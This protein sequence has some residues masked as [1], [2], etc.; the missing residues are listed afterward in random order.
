MRRLVKGVVLLGTV[1][2]LASAQDAAPKRKAARFRWTSTAPVVLP[3]SDAEH[4]V[5]AVK[6]PSIVFANGKYHVFMTTAGAKGWGLAYASFRRWEDAPAAPLTY[7]D[8]SPIGPGYRA[9]PQVFFF[10]PQKRW[11]MVFQGGDPLYSTTTNIDDPMSWSAPKPFF[12]A[13][14]DVVKGKDGN[15]T[16]LDFWVICDD[17]RCHL[18]NTG[19]NGRLYRSETALADFPRGFGKTEVVLEDARDR[20]FE[21]SMTYRVAGTPSYVT[22]VEAIGPR[23]RYFRAWTSDRLDGGWKPL[24]DSLADPFAGSAN[25][26]YPGGRWTLDVSHGEMIRAGNDQHLTLDPCRPLRF[27]YQGVDPKSAGMDYL[28]LPYRLGLLTATAPNPLSA[29]CRARPEG[30]GKRR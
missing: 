12:A 16:W 21:A 14:P 23:G 20:L 22:M 10:A 18:F 29:M 1:A 4:P 28:M 8:R 3:R 6:D 15:A 26:A 19:D 5:V 9:A 25:V 27:L 13:V 30:G 7:L 2:S 24:A 11:Y 17:T